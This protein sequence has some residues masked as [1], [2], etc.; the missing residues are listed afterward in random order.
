MEELISLQPTHKDEP[1]QD[2]FENIKQIK[3]EI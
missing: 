1:K 2:K 3:E